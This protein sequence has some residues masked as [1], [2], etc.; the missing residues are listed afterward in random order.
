MSVK[1]K[2]EEI[3]GNLSTASLLLTDKFTES[4]AI[5]FMDLWQLPLNEQITLGEGKDAIY[6]T[7]IFRTNQTL[8]ITVVFPPFAKLNLHSH[9]DFDELFFLTKGKVIETISNQTRKNGEFFFSFKDEPHRYVA[10]K[11]GA[12]GIVVAEREKGNSPIAG[13]MGFF[14]RKK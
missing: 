2:L 7:L 5:S 13:F 4:A 1:R 10:L 9:P 11:N 3:A 14:R 8:V 6:I 12:E